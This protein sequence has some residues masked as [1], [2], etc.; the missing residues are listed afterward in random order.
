MSATGEVGCMGYTVEEAFLKSLMSV[1]MEL[2]EENILITASGDRRRYEI[3]E[4]V[5][6]LEEMGYSLF[7][8]E[9]TAEFY[10]EKGIEI[11]MLYKIQQSEEPNIETYLKDDRLDLVISIPSMVDYSDRSGGPSSYG[12][13]LIRRAAVDYSVPLLNNPQTTKLFVK[14]IRK[15]NLDSLKVESWS[16]YG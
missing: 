11:E 10:R 14:S 3:L 1:G 16:S 2:P 6:M 9:H 12:A 8:T 7:G 5:R 4:A 15:E 13:K